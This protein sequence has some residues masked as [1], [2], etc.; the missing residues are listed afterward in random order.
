[1]LPQVGTGQEVPLLKYQKKEYI[2]SNRVFGKLP[3]SIQVAPVKDFYDQVPVDIKSYKN[4]KTEARTIKQYI[5]AGDGMFD[6]G[7]WAPP[8]VAQLPCGTRYLY[9]G[10][11]RRYLWILAKPEE[12]TMLAHIREV[13]DVAEISRLFVAQNKTGRKALRS[14]EVFVHEFYGGI[15]EAVQTGQ[16]LVRCNLKVDLGTKEPDTFVG[17]PQ[18]QQVKIEGFRKA[19]R[20]AG[21]AA[22]KNASD[23]IQS[24]WPNQKSIGVEMLHGFALLDSNTTLLTGKHRSLFMD[25]LKAQ[26]VAFITSA[27]VSTSLKAVGRGKKTNNFPE[28]VA[29]GALTNLREWAHQSGHLTKQTFNKYY[30]SE[31]QRLENIVDA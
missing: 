27:R 13:K 22:V 8:K 5:A 11:H 20:G 18:G 2:M 3:A 6:A 23:S 14:S 7:R 31:I 17:N 29:L 9:D 26:K 16:N 30:N 25:F 15:Q 24:V 19:V 1:M 21:L 10:D 12:K 28:S 4:R